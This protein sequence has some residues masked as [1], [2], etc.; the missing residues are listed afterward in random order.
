M[1][2]SVFG[3]LGVCARVCVRVCV[4]R[5]LVCLGSYVP[6]CLCVPVGTSVRF[7]DQQTLELPVVPLVPDT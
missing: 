2:V 1:F 5:L 4:C 6:V 3:S 7:F